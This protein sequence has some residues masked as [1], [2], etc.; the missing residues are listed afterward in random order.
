MVLQ[1]LSQMRKKMINLKE[2]LMHIKLR[3]NLSKMLSRGNSS[4]HNLSY[5]MTQITL[6]K[7][8]KATKVREM[9]LEHPIFTQQQATCQREETLTK[10][11]IMML[12]RYLQTQSSMMMNLKMT[13]N[14]KT[15]LLRFI[16]QEQMKESE[17]KIL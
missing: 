2:E 5:K 6:T 10:S 13:S 11:M 14:S 12:I 7:V 3:S 4:N 17:E 16:T 15:R 9:L 1:Q 8:D